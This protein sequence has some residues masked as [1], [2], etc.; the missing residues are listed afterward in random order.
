MDYNPLI[1]QNNTTNRTRVKKN[2][3]FGFGG[4]KRHAKSNTKDS[5]N[6]ISSFSYSKMKNKNQKG[7]VS[8]KQRK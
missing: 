2:Q 8:K 3:K 4:A 1:I 6:D 7:K 5:T